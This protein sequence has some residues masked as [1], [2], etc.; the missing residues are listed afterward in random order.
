HGDPLS[1]GFFHHWM[2]AIAFTMQLYLDFSGYSDMAIGSARL[3]GFDLPEN[4]RMPYL[5]HSITE[6]WQRWHISLSRWFRDYVYIPLGG[7][8]VG[9]IRHKWNLFAVMAISGLWH[10][11]AWTFVLWGTM[12]GLALVAEATWKQL[13][14]R[15]SK[16][17]S[18]R[19]FM[20]R[21]L[22]M[23]SWLY[24][25]IFVVVSDTLFFRIESI[26]NTWPVFKRLIGLEGSLA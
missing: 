16:E 6:H 3:L 20:G 5:S 19:A 15:S 13:I 1:Y 10:G 24:Q 9:P 23:G 2:A 25:I 17:R 21:I 12:H 14:P 8:R 7:N 26:S 4:F 18:G 11:A 22:G